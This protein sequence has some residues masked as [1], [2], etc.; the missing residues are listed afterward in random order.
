[1]TFHRTY[2]D[3]IVAGRRIPHP[4][5]DTGVWDAIR[6]VFAADSPGAGDNIDQTAGGGTSTS[7]ADFITVGGVCKPMNVPALNAVRE[8]QRQMNRVAQVKGFSKTAVD[9]AVGPGTLALFRQVQSV[10]TGSVMGDPSS[11]LSVAPDADVLGAQV[12]AVADSFGAPSTVSG[13]VALTVPTIV[14]KSGKV[15]APPVADAGILGSLAA[16]PP[17]QKVALVG[18]AGGIGYLLFTQSKKRRR[19]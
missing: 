10:A 9:G 16:M 6:S 1:M 14:T 17:I 3:G 7:V 13:P 4:M 11:C 18:V 12:K 5:G 15:V 8:L 2:P 19:R